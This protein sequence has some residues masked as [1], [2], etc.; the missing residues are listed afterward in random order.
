MSYSPR[1]TQ[2]EVLIE[3]LIQRTHGDVEVFDQGDLTLIMGTNI[4][5][6]VNYSDRSG[7]TVD[8]KPLGDWGGADLI[9]NSDS[10][11]D[12]ELNAQINK[13]LDA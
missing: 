13:A 12:D 10:I 5:W 7:Y 4:L 2:H 11:D 6:Y 8:Y 3:N 9:R 1:S